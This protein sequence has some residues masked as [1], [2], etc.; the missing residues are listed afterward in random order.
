LQTTIA[1]NAKAL[2]RWLSNAEVVLG[3]H[4]D[5]LNAINIFPV[6]A[7]DTG[8]NL[9]L[10]IR[11]AAKSAA[12]NHTSDVGELLAGASQAVRPYGFVRLLVRSP[13]SHD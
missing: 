13:F 3:N 8:T 9:Y 5:R 12:E 4:S 11:A 2:R 1:A 10:T 6:A 7:G